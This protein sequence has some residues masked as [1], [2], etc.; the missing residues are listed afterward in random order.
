MK[1]LIDLT[2]S[3]RDTNFREPAVFHHNNGETHE[4]KT[5]DGRKGVYQRFIRS[6]PAGIILSDGKV[7]VVIPKAELWKLAEKAEP[8]LSVPK[9]LTVPAAAGKIQNL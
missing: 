3:C 8:L 1:T 6:G 4:V 9:V 7:S 2:A 5:V